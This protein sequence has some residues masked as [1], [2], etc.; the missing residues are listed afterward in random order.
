[1]VYE[2]NYGTYYYHNNI[3]NGLELLDIPVKYYFINS[4]FL[5][6]DDIKNALE[7]NVSNNSDQ[8]FLYTETI[9]KLKEDSND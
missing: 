7:G 3:F 2:N 9:Y 8:G 1:M 6:I 5:T 4:A